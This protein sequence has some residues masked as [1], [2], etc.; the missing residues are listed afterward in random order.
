[1]SNRERFLYPA[2]L[3]SATVSKLSS[4]RLSLSC[5]AQA[6]FSRHA[7]ASAILYQWRV[8]TQDRLLRHF[9]PAC[10]WRGCMRLYGGSSRTRS[11]PTLTGT[12]A[13]A[14]RSIQARRPKSKQTFRVTPHVRL[15][16]SFLSQIFF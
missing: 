15:S 8:G 10:A 3:R 5:E 4:L 9:F 2:S 12:T 14:H 7:Q 13:A 6:R 1:M 16:V 11:S